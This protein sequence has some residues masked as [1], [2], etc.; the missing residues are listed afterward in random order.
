LFGGVL[1]LLPAAVMGGRLPLTGTSLLL[2]L[3][4]AFV[5]AA[6]FTLWTALLV[7]HEA[8]Q[9]LVFNMLIPVTG[10]LWSYLILGE[11]RI[12]EP[13]Y[14]VSILLTCIGIVL[15]NLPPKAPK[16]RIER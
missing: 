5:S 3:Y 7:L 2:V 11:A 9:I 10:A 14:L 12:F 8:G 13:L 16:G 6:A 15:V 1:I 4:L